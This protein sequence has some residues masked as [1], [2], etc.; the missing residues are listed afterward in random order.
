MGRKV[1]DGKAQ[2][3]TAPAGKIIN[4]G[5]LYRILGWNGS[6]IGNVVVADTARTL[7]F[8]ADPPAIYSIK[9]TVA[10][11]PAVGAFLYWATNDA[12][13]YQDGAINCVASAAV[14]GDRP[15]FLVTEAKNAAGYI[16][17]R[18]LN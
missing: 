8:E 10:L 7:A 9:C 12:T 2:N 14:A 5:D 18:I 16:R 3:R 11:T 13:T 6:A 15:C 17:G 1:S 4:D